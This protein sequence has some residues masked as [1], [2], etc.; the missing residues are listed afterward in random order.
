MSAAW[1]KKFVG[2]AAQI[3][4][5]SAVDCPLY[6]W[7]A[8]APMIVFADVE[9]ELAK[10]TFA[11]TDVSFRYAISVWVVLLRELRGIIVP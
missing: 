10:Y 6:N 11:C 8:E 9:D 2:S 7:E 1:E 4:T 3:L 5:I